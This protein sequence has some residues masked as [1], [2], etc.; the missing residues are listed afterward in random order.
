M[1]RDRWNYQHMASVGQLKKKS[2]SHAFFFVPCD[3]LIISS[4]TYHLFFFYF[5]LTD[6]GSTCS[7]GYGEWYSDYYAGWGNTLSCSNVMS[8]QDIV[9]CAPTIVDVM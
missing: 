4:F 1:T 6:C 5:T 3:M 8:P 9:S 7:Q 2:E